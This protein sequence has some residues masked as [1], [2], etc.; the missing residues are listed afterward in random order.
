M[1]ASGTRSSRVEAYV[2]AIRQQSQEEEPPWVLRYRGNF[3]AI[4][5]LTLILLSHFQIVCDNCSKYKAQLGY[6]NNTVK[7]VCYVCHKKLNAD[8]LQ[9]TDSFIQKSVTLSKVNKDPK[10][11]WSKMISEVKGELMW[12][13]PGK[14]WTRGWFSVSDM[15]LYVQKGKRVRWFILLYRNFSII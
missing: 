5:N 6:M 15:V 8:N 7:R 11:R 3:L 1:D 12:K 10:R 4:F 13:P 2:K 14:G 9:E